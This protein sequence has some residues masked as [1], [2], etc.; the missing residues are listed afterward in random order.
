MNLLALLLSSLVFQII[1]DFGELLKRGFQVFDNFLSDDV[2]IGEIGAVFEAF[3][4]EPEDAEI[5]FVA[6]G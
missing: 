3:V 2:G 4:F 5:E 1:R 6:L